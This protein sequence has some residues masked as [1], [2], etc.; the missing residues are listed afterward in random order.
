MKDVCPVELT[1]GLRKLFGSG[2]EILGVLFSLA[3][4]AA[5]L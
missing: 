3:N 2:V 1:L 5:F 4:E